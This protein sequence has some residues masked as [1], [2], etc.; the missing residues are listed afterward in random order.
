MYTPENL[1]DNLLKFME[2]NNITAA[3]LIYETTE[4][5]IKTIEGE[6]TNAGI[7]L[8]EIGT[9]SATKVFSQE[10]WFTA[11]NYISDIL[12]RW[13]YLDKFFRNAA[14][15]IFKKMNILVVD[16]DKIP[17]TEYINKII[18]TPNN[19]EKEKENP[20]INNN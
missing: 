8:M 1:R 11:P 16:S 6:Y 12:N 15:M 3:T 7:S 13:M 19:P 2:E 4:G 14:V 5:S 18:N 10:E 20:E 9:L 17:T